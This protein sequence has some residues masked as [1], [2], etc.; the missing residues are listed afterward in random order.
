MVIGIEYRL[1][2]NITYEVLE[3]NNKV[4]KIKFKEDGK[5]SKI[6]K[7][8][9]VKVEEVYKKIYNQENINLD[10]CYIEDFRLLDYRRKYGISLLD[11]VSI[12]GFS[13]KGAFFTSER[14]GIDFSY[15]SFEEK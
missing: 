14:V 4:V 7:Y 11:N 13:A 2:E 15:A 10:N 8:T 5:A 9:N 3:K 12:K 6:E 1:K